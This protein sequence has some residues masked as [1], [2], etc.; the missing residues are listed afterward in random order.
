MDPFLVPP[1]VKQEGQGPKYGTTFFQFVDLFPFPRRRKGDSCD[2][3]PDRPTAR[4]TVRPFD[5][6]TGL[7]TTGEAEKG[8]EFAV[9]GR[10]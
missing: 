7:Y 8:I 5:P 4:P 6:N 1:V 2:R 10:S 3:P 9:L